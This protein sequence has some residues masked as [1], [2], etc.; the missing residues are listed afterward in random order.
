[1]VL[2]CGGGTVDITMHRCLS[3]SPLRMAELAPPDG[4]DWGSTYVDAEFS[5]FLAQLLGASHFADVHKTVHYLEIMV[6]ASV[7]D[8][9]AL[10]RCTAANLHAQPC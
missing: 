3:N 10:V 4:G 9:C 8:T 1:M 2:D 5:T 6:R 7:V